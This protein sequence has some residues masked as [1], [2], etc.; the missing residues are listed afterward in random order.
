MNR[1]FKKFRFP[2]WSRFEHPYLVVLPICLIGLIVLTIILPRDRTFSLSAV[3]E[4]ATIVVRDPLGVATRLP[5]VYLSSQPAISF[6]RAS[7]EADSDV[8]I[9]LARKREGALHIQVKW[10]N[11]GENP[12]SNRAR[13]VTQEGDVLPLQNGENLRVMLERNSRSG[14][15]ASVPDTVV[16][17]FRGE[18]RVGQ[19]VARLV[20]RTLQTGRILIV[21]RQPIV[22]TRFV[23]SEAT[24]NAGDVV[25]WRNN[26]GTAPA[27]A[28]GFV[29]VGDG[30]G[31]QVTAHVAADYVLVNRY[32]AASYQLRPSVWDEITRDPLISGGI[33]LIGVLGALTPMFKRN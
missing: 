23:A 14:S 17:A 11:N 31:L 32:G 4:I 1:G 29:Q 7:L 28:T 24:L 9:E 21:E 5:E 26:Q 27:V 13:L 33:V 22:D 16:M 6:P 15:K 10:T 19:D 2:K 12:S 8:Q 18:L 20:E 30:P 25:E 3:T